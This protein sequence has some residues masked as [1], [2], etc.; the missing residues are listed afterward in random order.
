MLDSVGV[1]RVMCLGHI[2]LSF[3]GAYL[4]WVDNIFVKLAWAGLI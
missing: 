3:S 4:A 1:G 2:N